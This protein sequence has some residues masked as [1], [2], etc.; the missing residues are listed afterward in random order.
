MLSIFKCPIAKKSDVKIID[1]PG[2]NL[3]NRIPKICF[4]IKISSIIGAKITVP[5]SLVKRFKSNSANAKDNP[6]ILFW[7]MLVKYNLKLFKGFVAIINTDTKRNIRNKLNSL[8]GD[9]RHL[10]GV[11][12]FLLIKNISGN[13][14]TGD[15]NA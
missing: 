11:S 13:V 9:N 2:E 12:V 5:I 7:N 8:G 14:A 6:E 4:L 15:A 1:I 3:V 10:T